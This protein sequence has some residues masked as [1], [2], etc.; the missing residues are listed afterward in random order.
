M[1]AHLLIK[2]SVALLV[3]QNLV[4]KGLLFHKLIKS[5]ALLC[6]IRWYRLSN[7][8]MLEATFIDIKQFSA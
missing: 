2:E 6:G 4:L 5:F 3:L 7:L 1:I 8:Y